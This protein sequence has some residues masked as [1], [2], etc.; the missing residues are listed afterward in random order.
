MKFEEVLRVAT[1]VKRSL[2][3]IH[4][5]KFEIFN[6]SELEI[7][8]ALLFNK[9]N[10][11]EKKIY[12]QKI[13][14]YFKVDPV[15]YNNKKFSTLR[16]LKRKIIEIYRSITSKYL[17]NN[18]QK[19]IV[20]HYSVFNNPN[21]KISPNLTDKYIKNFSPVNLTLREIFEENLN[22]NGLDP[23][24]SAELAVKFPIIYLE[25]FIELN[26]AVDKLILQLKRLY[27]NPY[28]LHE[29]PLLSVYIAKNK[30]KLC[31]VQH[32]GN[33]GFTEVLEESIE[34]NSGIPFISWGFGENNI[35]PSRLKKTKSIIKIN[36]ILLVLSAGIEIHLLKKLVE[37]AE[38][39]NFEVRL[40]PRSNAI[41]LSAGINASIGIS[42]KELTKY[43]YVIYDSLVHT[44]MYQSII[45]RQ[46]FRVLNDTEI[47]SKTSKVNLAL[48]LLNKDGILCTLQELQSFNVNNDKFFIIGDNT[49]K[50]IDALPL[51]WDL[52]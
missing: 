23:H 29:D 21:R 42:A 49:S 32:G 8:I 52:N 10:L 47:G 37:I 15:F 11:L 50:Y 31:Y 16:I 27:I 41:I 4:Q 36:K 25:G 39:N 5:V 2:E 19:D 30:I 51:L 14:D 38:K 44:L 24:L 1:A 40:H 34:M 43:K 22:K 17:Y 45:N 7:F 3:E 26:A 18:Y 48:T 28:G 9:K 35:F 13:C 12:Q 33:Y 6:K 20:Y 46:K